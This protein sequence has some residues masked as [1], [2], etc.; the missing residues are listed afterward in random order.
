VRANWLN[1]TACR[2]ARQI[3]WERI[4]AEP[5]TVISVRLPTASERAA[6]DAAAFVPLISVKKPGSAERL[7]AADAVIVEAAGPSGTSD[8]SGGVW[9]TRPISAY[10]YELRNADSLVAILPEW[11]GYRL[12]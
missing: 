9:Q 3:A 5:G 2:A 7:Y 8:T 6:V 12:A 11:N 1:S 4:P 10:K